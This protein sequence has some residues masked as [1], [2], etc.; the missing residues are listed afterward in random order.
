[1]C[2][3][4]TKLGKRSGSSSMLKTSKTIRKKRLKAS[5][6]CYQ[7][8]GGLSGAHAGKGSLFA[9]HVNDDH[10]GGILWI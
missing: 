7:P 2:L 8:I 3:T 4:S 9:Y 5:F 6:Y 10:P 1:M